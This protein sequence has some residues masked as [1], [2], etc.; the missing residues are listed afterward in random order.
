M[1]FKGTK[2]W[3]TPESLSGAIE[4]IGGE[5]NALT[6]KEYT[7]YWAKV[8]YTQWKVATNIL[9]D[10]CMNPLMESA[11]I[12]RERNVIHE[13][14]RMYTDHPSYQSELGIEELMFPEH[15]MGREIVGSHE[16]IEGLKQSDIQLSLIHI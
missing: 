9:L 16:S 5:I 8:P 13:E 12:T 6:S 15:P 14:L 4:N 1:L 7:M 2:S 10:M 3:P 11:E